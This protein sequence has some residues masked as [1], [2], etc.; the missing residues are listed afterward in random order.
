MASCPECDADIDIDEFDVDEG[1]LVSC[2][3]CGRALTV[4][5]LTPFELEPVDDG[6]QEEDE[7]FEEEDELAGDEDEEEEEDWDE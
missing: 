6:D 7:G 2:Q 5:S 1:D 4:A 3:E